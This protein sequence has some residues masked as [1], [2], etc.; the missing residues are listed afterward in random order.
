MEFHGYNE[1]QIDDFFGI[2][3]NLTGDFT[4]ALVKCLASV[5]TRLK[6]TKWTPYSII[7]LQM[8]LRSLVISVYGYNPL[9]SQIPCDKCLKFNSALHA[10]YIK[11]TKHT[12]T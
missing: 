7:I 2:F 6:E 1:V 10:K 5:Y 3:H 4:K 12:V 11:D 9:C 8:F